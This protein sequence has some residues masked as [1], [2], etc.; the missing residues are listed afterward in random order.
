SELAT[1]PISD[2]EA[3]LLNAIA[4]ILLLLSLEGM[5]SFLTMKLPSF[6]KIIYGKPNVLIYEGKINQKELA[7]ERIELSELICAIRQ[8]GVAS[9][10]D[11]NHA[12][13][14]ENGKISVFPKSD[15]APVTPKQIR[16]NTDDDG[17]SLPLIMDRRI[18][19]DNLK[20][21]GWSRSKLDKELSAR[22]LKI[23]D[24]F[25]FSV[26]DCQNIYIIKKE[27]KK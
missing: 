20:I 26:D 9:V 22:K 11:V 10:E 15:S 13:L 2:T 12:I 24:V 14:E 8:N 4:P 6:R 18:I 16:G 19:G 25:L 5:L 21:R 7:R 23:D 27:N 3:P 1:I 17:I